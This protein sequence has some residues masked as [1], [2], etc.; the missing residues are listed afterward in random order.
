MDLILHLT[1]GC[2]MACSYCTQEHGCASM[3]AQVLQAACRLAF[4]DGMPASVG[5]FGGEP[6]LKKGLIFQATAYCRQLAAGTRLPV[7]FRITTNGILLTD[8]FLSLAKTENIR[9]ALS[10]DG[11]MQDLCRR[12]ADGGSFAAVERQAERLLRE[13]PEAEVM[14]TVAPQAADRFAASVRYLYGLGFRTVY[15]TPA[16]GKR[17][18]WDA[19]SFAALCLQ[20]EEIAAF[21]IDRRLGG[22]PFYFSPIDGKIQDLLSGKAPSDR[23]RLGRRSLS[24]SPDGVLYVCTQFLGDPAYRV[25]NVF[26]GID[27]AAWKRLAAKHATPA[28]C[29]GCGLVSRCVHSC[30]CLNFLETGCADRVSD[31]QCRY[32]QMLIRLADKTAQTLYTHGCLST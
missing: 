3:S 7:G 26:D 14:M 25:G 29:K 18:S 27:P 28:R 12:F 4:S 21:Y 13:Q 32:E 24:V 6:L 10:F 20:L 16:Y 9:T 22:E 30:G 15:A 23:C 8:A 31:F 19:P 2:N 1:S 5:F 11:L 17:V